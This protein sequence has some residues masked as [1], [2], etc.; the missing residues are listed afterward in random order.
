VLEMLERGARRSGEQA[1]SLPRPQR[2][3]P[4]HEVSS[5]Y[6]HL[7]ESSRSAEIRQLHYRLRGKTCQSIVRFHPADRRSSFPTASSQFQEAFRPCLW[8]CFCSCYPFPIAVEVTLRHLFHV[9]QWTTFS[10][11]V[12]CFWVIS[13]IRNVL[14]TNCRRYPP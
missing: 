7:F 12:G 6:A 11:P 1:P 9:Q 4:L 2:Q 8:T 10:S 14:E 13:R 5:T 3:H